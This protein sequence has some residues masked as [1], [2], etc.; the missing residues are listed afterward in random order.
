MPTDVIR[1][2]MCAAT[3]MLASL[4]ASA[5]ANNPTPTHQPWRQGEEVEVRRRRS[6]VAL[7]YTA[8][9]T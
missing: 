4:A 8:A 7:I 9:A 3:L 5:H 1:R 6:V 2:L